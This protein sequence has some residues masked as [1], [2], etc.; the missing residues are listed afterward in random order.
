[1][2]ILL[3][4]ETQQT[5][6]VVGQ[7]LLIWP[8][9]LLHSCSRTQVPA[10]P[11]G[12]SHAVFWYRTIENNVVRPQPFGDWAT[13]TLNCRTDKIASDKMSLWKKETTRLAMSSFFLINLVCKKITILIFVCL[14]NLTHK[15]KL[16]NWKKTK[17][18]SYFMDTKSNWTNGQGD[19]SFLYLADILFRQKKDEG[20]IQFNSGQLYF[21]LVRR[22][23]LDSLPF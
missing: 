19:S 17:N 13:H 9:R 11:S 15:E 2:R 14:N 1:M 3:T 12:V 20:L 21:F 16:H 10:S 7:P 8:W 22:R 6:A 4:F 23:C 5:N 18:E